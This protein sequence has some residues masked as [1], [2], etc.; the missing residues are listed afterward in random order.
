MAKFSMDQ[1]EQDYRN[2]RRKALRDSVKSGKTSL[3][4]GI[5]Q[6]GANR[7]GEGVSDTVQGIGAFA[8]SLYNNPQAAVE[9]GAE[10]LEALYNS[11]AQE[12]PMAA[13]QVAQMVAS[14]GTG[15]AIL[16]GGRI[17]P[18]AVGSGGG[19]ILRGFHSTQKDFD[20]IDPERGLPTG[21]FG[22]AAYFSESNDYPSRL[23][24][25]S[26]IIEAD[27]DTTNF[28]QAGKKIPVAKERVLGTLSVLN[29]LED[30]TGKPFRVEYDADTNTALV[31]Y[32]RRRRAGEEGP[33]KETKTFDFNN[34][35]KLFDDIKSVTWGLRYESMSTDRTNLSDF[36]KAAG[37]T[38]VKGGSDDDFHIGVFDKSAVK[39]FAQ[40]GPVMRGIGTLNETARNMFRGPRG[41]GAYQQ[42]ASGGEAM[43]PYFDVGFLVGEKE[44]RTSG[45]KVA[46]FARAVDPV[47]GI[48]RGM[49]ASGR[50]FDSDLPY[51]ERKAAA[52]EAALETAGAAGMVGIGALA[53]QPAKNVLMDVLTLT[54]A[55]SSVAE[56]AFLTP[57]VTDSPSD[58]SRRAFLKNATATV[59]V[60]AIA[61][62]VI[63]E[64]LKKGS[65]AA[66][67]GSLGTLLK[68]MDGYS[69]A[70][71]ELYRKLGQLTKQ[72]KGKATEE[73]MAARSERNPAL[74][75]IL[76]D[77]KT[78]QEIDETRPV[79]EEINKLRHEIKNNSFLRGAD[80]RKG[81][82]DLT[83]N[84]IQ[85]ATNDEIDNLLANIEGSESY[86]FES[87]GDTDA[88]QSILTEAKKRGMD[89]EFN[90]GMDP[91][92]YGQDA[93]KYPTTWQVI[94]DFSEEGFAQ[95]G[96]VMQGVGSLN[97]TARN[98]FRGPRGIGAYQQFADGGPAQN[99]LNRLNTLFENAPS[100]NFTLTE[101]P[102]VFMPNESE[103]SALERERL[104]STY[105]GDNRYVFE[106]KKLPVSGTIQY[107][108][109]RDGSKRFD[110]EIEKKFKGELGSIT[111]SARYSTQ[112]SSK[113]SGNTIVDETG[114]QVGF[115]VEGEIYIDPDS[116]NKLKG[117][118]D[119]ENS[120]KSR[121]FTIPE[122][123]ILK[124]EDG[125]LLKKFNLGVDLGSLGLD[126][127]YFDDSKKGT[128]AEGSA[129][130]KIGDNGIIKYN[131]SSDGRPTFSAKYA[132][133]VGD[134]EANLNYE[135]DLRNVPRYGAELNTK[136]GE[137][138]G[139]LSYRNDGRGNTFGAK[140]NITF[141]SGGEV[142]G[143]PPTRGPDPQGIGYFQQFAD[144]GPV[145]MSNGGEGSVESIKDGVLQTVFDVESNGD[146]N[147]W[148]DDAQ[149]IPET[150]LTQM[151]VSEIMGYQ[152][153]ENG[154]AAGA[155]QIK[156]NTF[157][158]LLNTGTLK[159]DEVFSP[160]VQRK[161]HFRLLDRRGFNEWVQGELSNDGFI[162]RLAREYAAVPLAQDEQVGDTL[163]E[164]GKSRYG[165]SNAHRISLDNMRNVLTS[166][167]SPSMA[168][169]AAL[170]EAMYAA[171][172]LEPQTMPLFAE[173]EEA[174]PDLIDAQTFDSGVGSIMS[175]T[176]GEEL[177]QGFRPRFGSPAQE[178]DYMSMV[179]QK[180][181][182]RDKY[183]T[184][185]I[186]A[187]LVG[188][189]EALEEGIGGLTRSLRPNLRP[190]SVEFKGGVSRSLMPRYR[191]ELEKEYPGNDTDALMRGLRGIRG[192]T[193]RK[194]FT[195]YVQDV[196]GELT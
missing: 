112:R 44:L 122:G 100:N 188:G 99:D 142:S 73:S 76:M 70:Q 55:P 77:E 78:V 20:E 174:G 127:T 18:S 146:F 92:R 103:L 137:G 80:L 75:G 154:P 191:P 161:A 98:M 155:G 128:R 59:G 53:K 52:L 160:Q 176:T 102:F 104:E 39:Q 140:Y 64:V 40:G 7:I 121:S 190:P 116:E 86:L 177:R 159:P 2:E 31:E 60:A 30:A 42:F 38:G 63:T 101:A 3:P 41:V 118:I 13:M 22:Q 68:N 180:I 93:A 158:Y 133:D 58:P 66:P 130:I 151:T 165:G 147:R 28:L 148:H 23:N 178:D 107:Q 15:A 62:E 67:K 110:A 17:D 181:S 11:V 87:L 186:A 152:R 136:F 105:G 115:A 4:V 168:S 126:A 149:N 150:P 24:P 37:F 6:H 153:G 106:K 193:L 144:G 94:Q 173:P 182:M 123:Q 25:N 1:F 61:P 96:E 19:N 97:E 189:K 132:T 187:D 14:G 91:A 95:G 125:T 89:K 170:D 79:V 72:I 166:L 32:N 35:S 129:T 172:Y 162:Q 163:R 175:P 192:R 43:K 113:R 65:K 56:D 50:A 9:S 183:S 120:K 46:D 81:V 84:K 5:L 135:N 124:T 143:P 16:R 196:R 108:K 194:G 90:E 8:K 117:A 119:V 141:A 179:P 164:S 167:K 156:Y 51:E 134:G 195:P 34:S 138:V 139:S 157:Q 57:K 184:E 47:Q 27:L 85:Q 185:N 36:M 45:R 82:E 88:F 109:N 74:K 114:R 131:D 12:D 33:I 145:Y 10:G 48:M 54:G 71:N 111:P 21:N 26:R 83:P 69:E 171:D 29:S 169:E 49:G